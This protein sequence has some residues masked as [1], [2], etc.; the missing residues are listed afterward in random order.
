MIVVDAEMS[1][2]NPYKHSLLSI[3]AVDFSRPE[4][5]FYGECRMW[6][7]AEVMLD[8]LAVNGFSEEQ[9]RDNNKKSE[10][11]LIREF[12]A[13]IQGIPDKTLAG[14]NVSFDMDFLNEAFKR[15]GI[16]W[17]FM[18]R[19]LDIHSVMYAKFLKE[20]R[21][22]PLKEDQSALSLTKILEALGL[23]P[24]PKP[25]IAINGAKYEAEAF[26][27]LIRGKNLLP[28]FA[29]YPVHIPEQGKLV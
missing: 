27:R 19:V 18:Y 13:W 9:C 29:Q 2:T 14:H 23:P 16:T 12:Y 10:T 17:K 21:E 15:A 4:R 28:E 26:S 5:Q 8:S 3:G 22:V 25:H 11:E 1:G 6:D 20:G 7:G 24:E